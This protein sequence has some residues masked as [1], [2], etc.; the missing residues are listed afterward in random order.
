MIRRQIKNKLAQLS[1]GGETGF[2]YLLDSLTPIFKEVK[3]FTP[4]SL[5]FDAKRA[6]LRVR[7]NAK[8]FQSFNAVKQRLEN[9]GFVV[10]Q[11]SLSNSGNLVAGELRIK[12]GS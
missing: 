12:V 2:L 4:E 8:D 3:E 7:A 10:E 11:G 1:N 9:S 6:E 5:R